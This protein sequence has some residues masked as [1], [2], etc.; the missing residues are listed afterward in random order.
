[1]VELLV[2]ADDFTGA[3]DTGVQ[4]ASKGI[5]TRV[6]VDHACEKYLENDVRV[7]VIDTE[8]RHL[9]AKA[10]YEIVY[11]II[12]TA[13]K[14]GIPNLYKKTDSALRGNVGSELSAF[15]KASQAELLSFLPAF[16]KMN[17]LVKNGVLY[18]DGLPVSESVFG[19]DPFD[20]VK[21]SS[22]CEVIKTQSDVRTESIGL[23]QKEPEENKG[24]HVYDCETNAQMETILRSLKEKNRWRV[25]AGCAGCAKFLPDMLGLTGKEPEKT[26]LPPN[27]LVMCGSVNPITRNQLD[28]GEQCG[29]KRIYLSPKQK[30]DPS[31]WNS[32]NGQSDIKT[33]YE[34]CQ[35]NRCCMI[36][37]NDEHPDNRTADFAQENQISLED[38]RK[39][40]SKNMGILLK[41]L[42]N[43]KLNHTFLITG[44]DTLL[45][46]MNEMNINELLPLREVFPGCVLT[47]LLYEGERC[48]VITKSGGFGAKTLIEDI[49]KILGN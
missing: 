22:V 6:I 4:F 37:T 33:F 24:I 42:L 44:G 32:D 29:F 23:G 28:Y 10:A 3:L 26:N 38:M 18:I 12:R 19:Q 43:K 34:E 27:L 31:Y 8:T 35:K 49:I 20:P 11:Q 15:L 41:Q 13:V 46:F 2:L 14:A 48:H 45:G 16:P 9:S 30:L 39:N 40:I 17:R 1:M 25:L 21:N 36:D 7:L 47:E 5:S